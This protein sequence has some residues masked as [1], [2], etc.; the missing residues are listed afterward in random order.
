MWCVVVRV[1]VFM[2]G[3]WGLVSGLSGDIHEIH[4]HRY[5]YIHTDTH[6]SKVTSQPGVSYIDAHEIYIDTHRY[7]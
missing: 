6:T 2:M 7:T 3:V 1:E 4:I 5:T